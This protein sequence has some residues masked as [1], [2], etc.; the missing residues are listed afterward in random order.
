MSVDA[1]DSSGE[2]QFGVEHNIFKQRIDLLGNPIQDAELESINVIHNST[3]NTTTEVVTKLCLSCYGARDGCCN[4]CSDVRDA[5]R[6]KVTSYSFTCY[7]NSI[8]A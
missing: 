5:Y 3:K 8:N 4:T 1:V 6:Q 2:Q 7:I